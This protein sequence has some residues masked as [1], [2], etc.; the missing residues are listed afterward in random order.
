MIR[1]RNA[2]VQDHR[3]RIC[4]RHCFITDT[5]PEL[6]AQIIICE[7]WGRLTGIRFNTE[8]C[9][10]L[11]LNVRLVQQTFNLSGKSIEIVTKTKYLG[12]IFSRSRLTTL[13]GK[14][15]AKVLEKAG[16]RVNLTRLR[17]T[18]LYGLCW[19]P[20]GNSNAWSGRTV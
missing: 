1:I 6:Q 8:K 20:K 18:L 3:I 19:A 7:R 4:G 12:I 14:H 17:R 15:I 10:V 5:P 9:K 11:F 13:Y 16:R 2:E